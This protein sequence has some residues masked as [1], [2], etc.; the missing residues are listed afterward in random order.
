M[1]RRR[2]LHGMRRHPSHRIGWD[3][4]TDHDP[5]EEEAYH[6]KIIRNGKKNKKK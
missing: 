4:H 1:G 2:H 6:M 3:E 5:E